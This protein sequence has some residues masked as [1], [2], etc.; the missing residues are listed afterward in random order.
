M[1]RDADAAITN[2]RVRRVGKLN[3]AADSESAEETE[4]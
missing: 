4:L 3:V 1:Q 2:A